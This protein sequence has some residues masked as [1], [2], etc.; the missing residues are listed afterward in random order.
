MGS[1]D[2]FGPKPKNPLRYLRPND[3]RVIGEKL[4]WLDLRDAF[5]DAGW[6]DLTNARGELTASGQKVALA[7]VD[8]PH[9]G[10]DRYDAVAGPADATADLR[11]ALSHSPEPALLDRFVSDG[12]DLMVAGHTHGGQVRVPLYGPPVTNCGI[13][14]GRSR[15]LSRW[16]TGY[17]HVSAGLG[18]SPYA[19]YRFACRPEATLLTLLPRPA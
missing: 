10:R 15:W 12:Y 3:Q 13:D 4:P 14:R 16:G 11:L 5:V 19:P 18:T 17:L 7:G 2:Y 8:D 9:L 6:I 1:N